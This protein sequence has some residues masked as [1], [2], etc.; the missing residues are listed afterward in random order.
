MQIL[1]VPMASCARVPHPKCQESDLHRPMAWFPGAYDLRALLWAHGG[2]WGATGRGCHTPH[3]PGSA[4]FVRSSY[5]KRAL[6]GIS[7]SADRWPGSQARISCAPRP[8][9]MCAPGEP[10]GAAATRNGNLKFEPQCQV[11]WPPPSPSEAA[12]E[13]AARRPTGNL[14]P[15]N[16]RASL[17]ATM[18]Q[19]ELER[20]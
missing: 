17:Q 8:G 6:F 10:L 9:H 18:L 11:E 7:T 5:V 15:L 4:H 12:L 16:Q 20:T 3:W 13:P 1:L 19:H 14:R 2:V